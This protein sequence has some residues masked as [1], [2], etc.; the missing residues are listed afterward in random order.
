M[1][2]SGYRTT[3]IRGHERAI[4]SLRHT[5]GLDRDL[6]DT[7]DAVRR[8]RN[9]S[10]YERAGTASPSEAEDVYQLVIGLRRQIVTWLHE[11][12]PELGTA[13]QGG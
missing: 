4:E 10:N 7:L 12:H 11:H 5:V 3:R 9:L 1:A 8:K 13:A 2:A 6:V